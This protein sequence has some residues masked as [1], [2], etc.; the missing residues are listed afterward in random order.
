MG[1]L[2]PDVLLWVYVEL[3]I[4]KLLDLTGSWLGDVFHPG[5]QLHKN[6]HHEG[7]GT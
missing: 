2:Y 6:C 7:L 4:G 5:S 1:P 3:N